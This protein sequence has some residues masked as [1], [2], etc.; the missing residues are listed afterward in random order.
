[1]SSERNCTFH[2][3]SCERRTS[4]GAVTLKTF[5]SEAV[6]ATKQ[7]VDRCRSLSKEG[8]VPTFPA[9][10]QVPP[11]V[12]QQPSLNKVSLIK[13]VCSTL[14]LISRP[15]SGR[16]NERG[17]SIRWPCMP[18]RCPCCK[19]QRPVCVCG[20]FF[21]SADCIMSPL[22][23]KGHWPESANAI[24]QRKAPEHCGFGGCVWERG[25]KMAA[26]QHGWIGCDNLRACNRTIT[27]L[28]RSCVRCTLGK[29]WLWKNP[30]EL[31]RRLRKEM[32]GWGNCIKSTKCRGELID[33]PMRSYIS[34]LAKAA[35]GRSL[36]SKQRR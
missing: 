34:C 6:S 16:M 9:V 29:M 3:S 1:M 24:M 32:A 14:P 35:W 12:E 13:L 11:Q 23:S 26:E 5:L 25:R 31:R 8:A 2:P 20:F 19:Q 15:P 36:I 27:T 33:I 22:T 17:R 18:T 4:S 30:T 21:S 7:P 10:G 28:R